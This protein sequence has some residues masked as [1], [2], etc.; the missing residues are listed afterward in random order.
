M[1]EPDSKMQRF[2]HRYG[3]RAGFGIVVVF[4]IVFLSFQGTEQVSSQ[5][6][7]PPQEPS[8]VVA[9]S[10][11]NISLTKI[12]NFPE[13]SEPFLT[14]TPTKTPVPT[15]KPNPTSTPK[16]TP[17]ALQATE[18]PTPTP[19]SE[20]TP[21]PEV[22]PTSSVDPNNDAIWD[23]LANCEAG[24]NWA[25]DTGN[26]YFGGLQFSQSA[27]ESVGGTGNPAHASREEQIM[28]G[29]MLRDRRG[30][31]GAWGA[32]ATRLGLP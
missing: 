12:E 25:T 21:T 13:V 28:R 22:P 20:P 19:T 2:F 4:A 3:E 9:S 15:Q 31:F 26:G 27:W 11:E 18:V 8:H 7:T 10:D 30:S 14:S 24:N 16:P 1:E 6:S 23:Q 29:K 5:E 17:Q 32:C